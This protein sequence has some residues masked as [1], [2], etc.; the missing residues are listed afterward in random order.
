MSDAQVTVVKRLGTQ[1]VG[2]GDKRAQ[3]VLAFPGLQGP[4]GDAGDAV[5][6]QVSSTH[7]QWRYVGAASWTDLIALS[8]LEGPAGEQ[9]PP[10]QDLVIRGT[11]AAEIDLDDITSPDVG[12]I[13]AVEATGDLWVWDGSEWDNLGPLQGPEGPAGPQG[14]PGEIGP[15]GD[16]GADGKTVL[17]GPGAPSSGLGVDGDF[18]ID[19]TAWEIYGPKTAGAWGTGES[20]VGPK[21]DTGETGATGQGVPTGGTTG[22]SLVK[23]SGTNYD[24]TWATRAALDAEQTF[25]ARQT[26]SGGTDVTGRAAG[27][28]TAVAA[29]DIDCSAGNYFTKTINANSTFTFS[30]VPASRSYGF[31][32]QLTVQGTRTITWPASVIWPGGTVPTFTGEKTHLV[33]FQ[34]SN[35][36]T[37]FRGAALTD[38]AS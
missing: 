30:N 33:M 21:G 14:E 13:Y 23:V 38:Y 37:T 28:V 17:N 4:P 29:L 26:F 8:E 2:G 11:V 16:A 32:L 1:V 25:T 6:F 20:L 31:T 12:D 10:G 35:G 15:A 34:T 18:Y 27:G 19:T 24:T 9:G 7:I 5:E 36:G 3:A 22:Q